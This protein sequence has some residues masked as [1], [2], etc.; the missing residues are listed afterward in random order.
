MALEGVECDYG[1]GCPCDDPLNTGS[2]FWC[3]GDI[4]GQSSGGCDCFLPA[5]CDAGAPSV[6]GGDSD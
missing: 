3:T 5:P 4:W 2:N 1:D 6:D